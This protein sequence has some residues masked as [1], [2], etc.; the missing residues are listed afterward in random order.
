MSLTIYAGL[1]VQTHQLMEQGKDVQNLQ[2]SLK[3][4]QDHNHRLQQTQDSD[5]YERLVAFK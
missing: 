3:L 2:V 5:E 1:Y 4:L